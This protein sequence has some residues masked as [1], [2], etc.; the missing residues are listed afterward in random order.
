LNNSYSLTKEEAGVPEQ[1]TDKD[2]LLLGL[3]TTSLFNRYGQA[4]FGY[5]RLHTRSR[6]EIKDITLEVFQAALEHDNLSWLNEAE[7][8]TWLR[9]VASNKIVDRYRRATRHPEIT[10]ETISETMFDDDTSNPEHLTLQQEAHSHLHQVIQKLPTLQQQI[11]RL[12]Y[13]D[14]LSFAEIGRLLDKEETTVRKHHSRILARL[15]ALY[16]HQEGE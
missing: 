1:Q 2:E 4:I 8:L 14:R 10:L 3:E 9:R 6:E 5:V 11:L 12:R 15:R 7:Q 13:G 16:Q